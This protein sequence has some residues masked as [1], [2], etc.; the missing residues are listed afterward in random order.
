MH[1][2]RSP[3]FTGQHVKLAFDAQACAGPV[4]RAVEG[5]LNVTTD[6]SSNLEAA[7]CYTYGGNGV[8]DMTW[9]VNAAHLTG[10][11]SFNVDY[12]NSYTVFLDACLPNCLIVRVVSRRASPSSTRRHVGGVIRGGGDARHVDKRERC[13]KRRL[14][15]SAD[16]GARHP[17]VLRPR[18]GRDGAAPR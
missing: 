15:S 14:L 11:A 7:Q 17:G 8:G 1:H 13:A 9:R 16:V 4:G 6:E 2:C 12:S 3:S 10:I 5:V 18:G